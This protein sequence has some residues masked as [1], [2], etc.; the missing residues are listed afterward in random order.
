MIEIKNLSKYY[1]EQKVL[2][3]INIKITSPSF[4]TIYGPSGCGK[5]TLLNIVSLLD[6]SY[7]GE[8]FFLGKNVKELTEKERK[9]IIS[10]YFYYIFQEPKLI[11]NESI[12]T[13]LELI[14]NSKLYDNDID[15][16]LKQFN[17]NHTSN[18]IVKILS[19]GEKKRLLL[20]GGKLKNSRII[21]CDEITSSLDENNSKEVMEYLKKISKK[22][23]VILV[24]HDISL[25]EQYCSLIYKIDNHS[26][27]KI[28]IN[29]K[30]QIS[31][32]ALLDNNLKIK[33]LIK[34]MI[35]SIK[36]KKIR[37]FIMIL[38]LI[39]SLFTMGLSFLITD[40]VKE[41]YKNQLS[42]FYS[43]NLLL[44]ENVDNSKSSILKVLDINNFEDFNDNYNDL[45][46][47]YNFI[48]KANFN[49]YFSS[50]NYLTLDLNNMKY[51][52]ASYGV[53]NVN[54]FISINF[55]D[56]SN[57]GKIKKSNDII[58][59]LNEKEIFDISKI[60]NLPI[61]N[62]DGLSDYFRANN[63]LCTLFLAQ[64][65]WEYYIEISL[66]IVDFVSSNDRKIIASSFFNEYVIEKMMQLPYS[67]N[68]NEQDYYPWT[69]KKIPC[70]VIKNENLISFYTRFILDESMNRYSFHLINK[71]QYPFFYSQ[72]QYSLIYFTYK[73][74]E[75]IPLK[76]ID[77]IS[78]KY[79]VNY[80]LPCENEGF[81][82]EKT[83]LLG[84][85]IHP[86]YLCDNIETIDEFID[87][88]SFS[89]ADLGIYQSSKF[90][91]D[92][93][94]I[95]SM[96]FMDSSK[97]NYVKFMP[98]SK[99]N[100]SIIEG[101]MPS[102]YNE[103]LISKKLNEKLNF[104]DKLFL[105]TL[106]DVT[107]ERNNYRNNFNTIEFKI[108]GIVNSDKYEI[109]Q[110]NLFPLVLS[111]ILIN[112]SNNQNNIDSCLISFDLLNNKII[113]DIQNNYPMYNFSNPLNNYLEEI[114]K[115]VNY[116]SIGLLIFSFITLISCLAMMALIIYLLI[117]EHEKDIE[118]YSLL[119]YSKKT[120]VLF[121]MLITFFISFC[122]FLISSIALIFAD[123]FIF[124]SNFSIKNYSIK[125]KPFL[126]IFLMNIFVNLISFILI[127]YQ[128]SRKDL[129]SL[130][131]KI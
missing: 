72:N 5:S 56:S 107:K 119:G 114:N 122:G 24:T 106:T 46:E 4:L 127:Y 85:F 65:D 44:M 49:D 86:T 54:E 33:Y 16:N 93:E 120:I 102:Q 67:Y 15:E 112:Y 105:T 12:K 23:I 60:L 97:N 129:I 51:N 53:D 61:K 48:Y 115:S 71:K 18:E 13:N 6:C 79:K 31:N 28:E 121:F 17:I 90:A 19:K 108:V 66:N 69:V 22:C 62:K 95:Y 74:N 78:N 8:Y 84:G 47:G 26:L 87:I 14:S 118:V 41:N 29:K 21:V 99:N 128:I 32:V 7:E 126:L 68:L 101:K 20:L 36:L 35:K 57:K 11:E 52:L 130:V 37:Y 125:I 25:A 96:S 92:K 39:I 82:V 98:Y 50:E 30:L 1:N 113:D 83:S 91:L 88:N 58:I 40:Q 104:K 73:N 2:F 10:N 9:K 116:L 45:I 70:Q 81:F 77:E 89:D 38:S 64:E 94:K 75:S 76:I 131:K 27:D 117:N 3:N 34:H 123:L 109:Y 43:S 124:S 63:L 110:E 100:F 80:Y 42:S 103:I 59:A 111:E 55:V